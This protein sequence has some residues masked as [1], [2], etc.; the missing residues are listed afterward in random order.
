MNWTETAICDPFFY[1]WHKHVDDVNS[2]FQDASGETNHPAAYS[3][4]DVS[5]GDR[6]SVV[7]CLSRN[8][9]GATAV[10]FDF[11]RFARERLGENLDGADALLTNELLTRFVRSR[12]TAGIP[13]SAR[14][15]YWTT[16]LVHE[17]FTYFVRLE[18]AAAEVRTVTVR[19]FLV[20]ATLVDDRRAWIELDK[21]EVPL[22]PGINVL[23]RPDARSSVIKRRGVSAPGAEALP[24]GAADQWCDCGWP[25][26]LLIPSG[27]SDAQGTPFNLMVA[28]TDHSKDREPDY[29]QACG[30]MSYCGA[31]ENYPD[32]RRMGYPF[33]RP[34]AGQTITEAIASAPSMTSI[35]VAIR[36]ETE[37]PPK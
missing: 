5:F 25:Y 28:V 9:P 10:G 3:P 13:E 33:D 20:H 36:C 6:R 1:R 30:S 22:A 32:L 19:T 27:A 26:S 15:S 12:V 7:I 18:N 4:P 29:I 2:A 21:F 24:P 17:P 14:V 11:D 23:G 31:L 8:I 34:F 37:R 35:D 16:H